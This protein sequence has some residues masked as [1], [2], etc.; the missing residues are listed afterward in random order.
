MKRDDTPTNR[1]VAVDPS[2]SAG[3]TPA[4]VKQLYNIGNYAP[5]VTSGSKTGF[6]AFEGQSAKYS[7]LAKYEQLNNIP[8]QNIIVS[9]I[10]GGTNQQNFSLGGY[11]DAN[12]DL[13]IIAGMVHPLPISEFIVGGVDTGIPLVG[14]QSTIEPFLAHYQY[15]LSLP[16]AD[17]P[18]VITDSYG[19][20]EQ[21]VPLVYAKRVCN[22]IELLGLRGVSVSLFTLGLTALESSLNMC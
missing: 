18:Q 7:D 3:F 4:C 11:G 13:H 16:D 20:E 17:L 15:L 5:C 8:S 12:L 10:N 21:A 22:S 19:N 6:R 9:V 2:C 14:G 1:F